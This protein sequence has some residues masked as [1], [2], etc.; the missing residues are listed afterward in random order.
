MSRA[1]TISPSDSPSPTDPLQRLH[2]LHLQPVASPEPIAHLLGGVPRRPLGA[3]T[4]DGSIWSFSCCACTFFKI[5]IKIKI[6]HDYGFTNGLVLL[7]LHAALLH[8]VLLRLLLRLRL[9][10]LVVVEVANASVS[11]RTPHF[12]RSCA[13]AGYRPEARR[14]EE[15]LCN[16]K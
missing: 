11:T 13:T 7:R 15:S 6:Q 3:N 16:R 1:K 14:C 8:L 9:S 12:F 5:K 10:S 4:L 2:V